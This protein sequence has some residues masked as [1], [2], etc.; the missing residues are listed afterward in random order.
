MNWFHL[1]LWLVATSGLHMDALHVHAGILCQIVAALLLRRSLASPL[2][3]LV[4]L[5][6]VLANEYYDYAFEVWPDRSMQLAEAFRD[7]WNT[8]LVPTLI[9]LLVRFVPRLFHRPASVTSA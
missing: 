4:V 9:L 6:A 1:K 2:P 7:S 5:V 8:L 3:W